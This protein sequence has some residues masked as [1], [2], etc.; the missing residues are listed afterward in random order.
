[1]TDE[2]WA[3]HLSLREALGPVVDDLALQVADLV[4][5]DPAS[6]EG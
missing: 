5:D 3:E 1:M 4:D 6:T 2:E